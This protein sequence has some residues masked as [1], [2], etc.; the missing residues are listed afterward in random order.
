MR[1]HVCGCS[2]QIEAMCFVV[3]DTNDAHFELICCLRVH[4]CPLLHDM[5]PQKCFWRACKATRGDS[6]SL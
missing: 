3:I 5:G 6:A 1:L 2:H 4:S